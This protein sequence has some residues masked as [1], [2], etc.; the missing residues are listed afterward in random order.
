MVNVGL[1]AWLLGF[2]GGVGLV[3]ESAGAD[4]SLARR[5]NAEWV[6]G[7]LGKKRKTGAWGAGF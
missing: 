7:W 2:M 1:G 4:P 6:D 5:A 3:G